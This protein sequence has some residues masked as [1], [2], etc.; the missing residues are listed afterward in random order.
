LRNLIDNQWFAFADLLLVLTSGAVWVIK[1]DLGAW[2][3]LIALLPWGLRIFAGGFPFRRTSFDWLIAIFVAT[4]W[5]GYWAAY[6]KVNAWNKVWLI[7]TA[8]LLYYAL[9]AQ[10]KENWHRITILFFSIGVIVSGYYFL[11]HDFITSPRKLSFVNRIGSLLMDIRPRTEWPPIHPNYVAGLVSLTAPFILYPVLG[12]EKKTNMKGFLT[13]TFA[14]LGLGVFA[15]TLIMTT[16]RGAVLAIASGLGVWLLWRVISLNGIRVRVK[17]DAFFPSIVMVY[18]CA[19]IA[20]LYLGPAT[21][22]SLLSNNYYY[23]DGSRVELLLR[24]LYLLWDY[25]FTGGGLGAFSGLY[26]QYLLNIPYFNVPNSHNLFLDVAIELG[27]IGG[28]TFV[29]MYLASIWLV[30]YS[31]VRGKSTGSQIL[32]WIILFSLVAAVVHGMVDDYLFTGNGTILSVFLIAFSVL[33]TQRKKLSTIGRIKFNVRIVGIGLLSMIVILLV[34]S[35]IVLSVWYANLGSVLMS[36]VELEGFPNNGWAGPAIASNLEDAEKALRT[37]LQLDP[38]NRTAN[39]RL[40]MIA[41]LRQNFMSA[42]KHLETAHSVAPEHR[43]IVKSLGYCYVWLGNLEKAE[44]FLSGI[45]EAHE[46]MDVYIWWWGTQGRGDLSDNAALALQ[47]LQYK[48]NQP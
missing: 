17:V 9:I 1:P 15:F 39:Q 14:L 22:G 21:S 7:V 3:I 25:P 29:A 46:E 42:S 47:T 45:P 18:L 48:D 19:I 30:S 6:D 5:V 16:S 23:G 37:S 43:G 28:L 31:I 10:P 27:L 24:S 26:S 34:F 40:G 41:M 11:T 32:N 13:Y 20:F 8:A 2:I 36:Q 35:K 44:L 33:V 38:N 4:A 12:M